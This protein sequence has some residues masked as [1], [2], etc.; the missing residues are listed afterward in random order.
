MLIHNKPKKRVTLVNIPRISGMLSYLQEERMSQIFTRAGWR[1]VGAFDIPLTNPFED[2]S[3]P[4]IVRPASSGDPS[5]SQSSK[6]AGNMQTLAKSSSITFADVTLDTLNFFPFDS[7]AGDLPLPSR[8][9]MPGVLLVANVFPSFDDDHL[10]VAIERMAPEAKSAALHG[11]FPYV[12]DPNF[13]CE[14]SE[15]DDDE[16]EESSFLG[17]DPSAGS[18]SQGT[19]A[20]N[21]QGSIDSRGSARYRNLL[22]RPGGQQKRQPISFVEPSSSPE[23][24]VTYGEVCAGLKANSL[25][26]LEP[27]RQHFVS[28][29]NKGH[30]FRQIFPCVVWKYDKRQ[31]MFKKRRLRPGWLRPSGGP[32]TLADKPNCVPI[33]WCLRE[34]QQ[35]GVS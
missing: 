24:A 13:L 11:S 25:S 31:R 8:R 34:S 29:C 28:D 18:N 15:E 20:S 22:R 27:K 26:L 14:E 2:L 5:P 4:E 16:E 33:G 3:Q 1:I 32:T 35:A 30:L 12:P 21:S 6:G 17:S 23:R 9:H 7:E 19:G 10:R